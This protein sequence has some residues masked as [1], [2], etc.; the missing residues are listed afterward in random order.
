LFVRCWLG[1]ARQ[2]MELDRAT[3]R[4]WACKRTVPTR[5]GARELEARWLHAVSARKEEGEALRK[6][7]LP[8]AWLRHRG[9]A[10]ALTA[11]DHRS[12]AT[13]CLCGNAACQWF[14][15][16][17]AGEAMRRQLTEA[18][19]EHLGMGHDQNFT[20]GSAAWSRSKRASVTGRH[21]AP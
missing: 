8:G 7:L 3:R 11:I 16:E 19:M 12:R 20:G 4:A 9:G 5:R 1:C 6:A 15:G 14:V 21:G 2:G 18:W 13:R 17:V 10:T